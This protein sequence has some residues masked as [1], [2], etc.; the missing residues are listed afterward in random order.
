MRKSWGHRCKFLPREQCVNGAMKLHTRFGLG[1]AATYALLASAI[2]AVNFNYASE[3]GVCEAMILCSLAMLA[4][5][6]V[7]LLGSFFLLRRLPGQFQ[8]NPESARRITRLEVLNEELQAINHNYMEMLGFVAHELKNQLSSAVISL[9]TVKDGYLGE[10]TPAQK[11]S[12]E[13][14]AH[15]LEGFQDMIQNYLDLSRLETGELQATLAYIPLHTRVVRPVLEALEGE[16]QERQLAVEDRIPDGKVVRADAALL[17]IVYGNLLSNAV[18]YGRRGGTILLEVQENKSAVTLS[19][20][21]D[22]AG[23][24]PEQIPLLFKKFSRLDSAEQA[25]ERGTGL[26]LYICRSIVEKHGGEIW[27]DSKMG[28]WVRISFTLPMEGGV[29]A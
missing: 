21:N 15:S 19:V 2:L 14:L 5:M 13:S 12:L 1:I 7:A 9:Y 3:E 29:Q 23:I 28:E 11:R 17:R 10:I 18:K 4:C 27:A 16:L 25:R 26:G 8:E 24:P 6:I 20:R 22:S